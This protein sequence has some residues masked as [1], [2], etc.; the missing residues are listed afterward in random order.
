MKKPLGP[1]ARGFSFAA[2]PPQRQS[3]QETQGSLTVASFPSVSSLKVSLYA[4]P[5]DG[6][7]GFRYRALL[8]HYVLQVVKR[9]DDS[10][11]PARL[12]RYRN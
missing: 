3:S 4:L 5:H 8:F 10:A 11:E 7:D 1:K 9:L 6:V 2:R 12:I